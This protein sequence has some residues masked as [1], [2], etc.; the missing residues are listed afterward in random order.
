[1]E[2][3]WIETAVE[4]GAA[5]ALGAAVAF[6][7]TML[8]AGAAG[9]GAAALA[10]AA[11]AAGLRLVPAGA[12]WRLPKFEPA[13]GDAGEECPPSAAEQPVAAV[14]DAAA[15]AVADELLL[16]DPL[17][18]PA[19]Q[20]RV[21]QL[22]GERRLPTPGELQASIARHLERNGAPVDQPDAAAAL[23]AALAELRRSLR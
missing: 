21:V 5:A 15:G 7:A 17:P 20:S 2:R 18:P 1:M 19:E 23:S 12:S 8:G 13:V 11:A 16:D 14:R 10:F 22:F 3:S 9:V 4:L 6:A